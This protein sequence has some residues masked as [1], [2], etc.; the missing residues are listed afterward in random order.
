[1]GHH[2]MINRLSKGEYEIAD[3][4]VH[5]TWLRT[6]ASQNSEHRQVH[7]D[8][9]PDAEIFVQEHHTDKP[10][11]ECLSTYLEHAAN[12]NYELKNGEAVTRLPD[13]MR[14]SFDEVGTKLKE[15]DEE[16]RIVAMNMAL[17]QAKQRETAALEWTK[18][19]NRSSTSSASVG[20]DTNS[21]PTFSP[22]QR[23]CSSVPPPLFFDADSRNGTAI[24]DETPSFFVQPLARP[25][26][27]WA[28]FRSQSAQRTSLLPRRT[29]SQCGGVAP[30]NERF[31]R[32][33]FQQQNY[34]SVGRKSIPAQWQRPPLAT[35]RMR[36][37]LVIGQWHPGHAPSTPRSKPVL[38]A[39]QSTLTL[40]VNV[41]P[42]TLS[43]EGPFRV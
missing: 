38:P 8:N 24:R 4:K 23:P 21:P 22:T 12:V 30:H 37:P 40:R 2:L 31:P 9:D 10:V 11:L 25:N 33:A 18:N 27:R 1:M 29:V 15:G 7:C 14:L 36:P 16:S 43:S 19:N 6:I 41:T 17:G 32:W 42:Q 34:S 28:D 35:T 3:Q 5:L 39:S 20:V 26:Q 13:K